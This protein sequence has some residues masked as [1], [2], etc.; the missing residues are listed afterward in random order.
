MQSKT[1]MVVGMHRSGTS[2][3]SNWLYQCGLQLGEH[4]LEAN[5]G[6]IEGHF[7]DVEFLRMHEEILISNAFPASG[8]VYDKV[9]DISVY[10]LEK[11]KSVIKI[12]NQLYRQWGWK[13]PRTCLFLDLYRELLPNSKYLVIVRDYAAVVHSLLKRDFAEHE[14]K[15]L[16]RKKLQRLVW[17][18]FRRTKTSRKFYKEHA[19]DY[20][21]VYIEYNQHILDTLK[22]LPSEDYM[23]VNYS[24]LEKSDK[25]V[26]SFLTGKWHF[27][28]QYHKFNEVYKKNLMSKAFN[29]DAYIDDKGLIDKAKIITDELKKYITI[30]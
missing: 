4:L 26:F 24:M 16:H 29:V 15:Y 22:R 2:L 8:Y 6:N 25:E 23:V 1:L 7:E 17:L 21:K 14:E 28:L 18:Y 13:E 27:K 19:E 11:L 20:L 9:I 12:K 10:Q 5:H 3:I 30:H